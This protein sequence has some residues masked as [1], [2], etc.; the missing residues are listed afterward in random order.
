M[1]QMLKQVA[2]SGIELVVFKFIKLLKLTVTEGTLNGI[3]FYV[4]TFGASW[5]SFFPSTKLPCLVLP[6]FIAWLNLDLGTKTSFIVGLNPC[7]SENVLAGLVSLNFDPGQDTPLLSG[8]CRAPQYVSHLI[9]NLSFFFFS[10]TVW[11]Q[12]EGVSWPGSKFK[13]HTVQY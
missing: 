6:V 13:V 3:T 12:S 10:H 7:F 1:P 4:K 5:A 9:K 2:V 11:V 8:A